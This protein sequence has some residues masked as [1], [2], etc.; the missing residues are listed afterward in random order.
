MREEWGLELALVERNRDPRWR[1]RVFE[2]TLIGCGTKDLGT[3]SGSV[4]NSQL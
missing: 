4:V 1:S 3:M 2:A